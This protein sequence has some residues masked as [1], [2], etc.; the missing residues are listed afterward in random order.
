M[1]DDLKRDF[2]PKKNIADFLSEFSQAGGTHHSALVY[3]NDK[4]IIIDFGNIMGWKV[5]EI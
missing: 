1:V 4:D 3:G 2:E 5:I